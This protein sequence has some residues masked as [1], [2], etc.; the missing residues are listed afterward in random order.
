[1]DV[2]EK[3]LPRVKKYFAVSEAVPEVFRE[4]PEGLTLR[5][6]RRVGERE[7]SEEVPASRN[8]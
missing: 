2:V 5:V 3:V 7:V 4:K 6:D 1:M 8:V